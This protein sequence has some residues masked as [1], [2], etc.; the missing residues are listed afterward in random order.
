MSLAEQIVAQ[1]LWRRASDVLRGAGERDRDQRRAAIAFL[2]RVLSAAIAFLLQVFL[3]RWIGTFEYGV[4]AYVWIWVI[5]LGS[6]SN[7]GLNASVQRFVPEYREKGD[8]THLRG[9]ISS[10]LVLSLAIPTAIA[11]GGAGL[12]YVIQD[13]VANHYVVPLYLAAICLPMFTLTDTQDGMARSFSWIDLALAPPYILRPLLL[14]CFMAGAVVAGAPASAVTA[15]GAAIGATWVAALGQN[16]VLRRRIRARV[17]HGPRSF[18]LGYWMSI[19]APFMLMDG[20]Y[21]LLGHLDVLVLDLFTSPAE[22]AVYYAALKTTSLIAFVFF[23]VVAVVTP[24][25]SELSSNG[26][27]AG[28]ANLLGAS[29]AWIFWPSLLAA[30]G[31]LALGW[32]LLWLFG[33]AF[34]VAYPVMF[35]LVIGMLVRAAMG[36]V[37]PLLNMLG[38]QKVCMTVLMIATV[39]N[40]VLNFALIPPFGLYGAAAATTIAASFSAVTLFAFAKWR[41]GLHS[42]V[43]GGS[44][45]AEKGV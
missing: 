6:M 25:F 28:L 7:F 3:A 32:P 36:P 40:V 11:L 23:A 5:I 41:L 16:L 18:R 45:G 44:A 39:L 9:V 15:V 10:S 2:I 21:L 43:F 8:L 37:D 22:I 14:L 38:H 20:F 30:A 4:F 27:H 12:L 33:P 42:C 24:K 19:S 17:S 13:Y 26:D 35:V 1:P 34:T 31:I 29:S